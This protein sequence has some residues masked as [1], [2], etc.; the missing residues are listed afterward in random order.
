M[1]YK[2][3]ITK[4]TNDVPFKNKAYEEIGKKSDGDPEYG[5]VYFD[6]TKTVTEDVFE[7]TVDELNIKA[8]VSVINGIGAKQWAHHK[9]MAW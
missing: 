3:T 2:V 5:Y 6:D 7:Q 4:I 9:M 1:S 8:V